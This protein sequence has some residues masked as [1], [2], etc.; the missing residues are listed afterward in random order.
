M[1]FDETFAGKKSGVQAHVKKHA[2]HSVFIHCHCYKLQ[3]ACVQSANSTEGIKHVYTT[4]TTL[5]KFFCNSP[6]RCQN[7]KEVQKV[8][9]L[10]MLKIAKPSD[11]RWLS[12]EKCMSTVKKCYGVIV[13]ALENI[14]LESHEPEALGMSKILLKPSTLFAIYLLDYI[15]PQVSKLSETLQKRTWTCP[16]SQAFVNATL[17]TLEDVFLPAANWVLNLLDVK[18]EMGTTVGINFNSENITPN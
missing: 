5:W 7:L 15:L 11:T 6:K 3:M 8:L 12:H 13:S 14:Y 16:S 17:H 2:P 4:I 1:I 18:E 10:P 9:N